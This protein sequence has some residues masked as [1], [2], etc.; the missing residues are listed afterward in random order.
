L[1]AKQPTLN[2]DENDKEHLLWTKF[3]LSLKTL[4]EGSD[5]TGDDD[6]K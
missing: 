3:E 6:A 4:Q 2:Y 5:E 1:L